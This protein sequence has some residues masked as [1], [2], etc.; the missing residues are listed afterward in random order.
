MSSW[1]AE[2]SGASTS[3]SARTACTEQLRRLAFGPEHQF[4][5]HAGLDVATVPLGGAADTGRDI[6]MCN[7]PGRSVAIHPGG[8]KRMAA[9]IFWHEKIGN[10]DHRDRRQHEEIPDA[11]SSCS[12]S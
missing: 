8:N 2:G 9:F 6:V 7:A 5:R 10:F 3:S 1:R 12:A 4:V 11:I